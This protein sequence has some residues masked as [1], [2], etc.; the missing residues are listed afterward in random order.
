MTFGVSS[1]FLDISATSEGWH[2]Q[3]ETV[4]PGQ[5]LESP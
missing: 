5:Q 2:V 4:P 3:R 1:E